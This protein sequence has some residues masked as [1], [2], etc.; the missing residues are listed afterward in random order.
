M[1]LK[2]LMRILLQDRRSGFFVKLPYALV[3]DQ[4]SAADFPSSACALEFCREHRLQG[5]EIV[6]SF[7]DRHYDLRIELTPDSKVLVGASER[8]QKPRRGRRNL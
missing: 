6:L 8:R 2:R 4:N 3:E 1:T 5:F 7:P